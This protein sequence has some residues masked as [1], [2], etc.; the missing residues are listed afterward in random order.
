MVAEASFEM[1]V[2]FSAVKKLALSGRFMYHG[3]FKR[4]RSILFSWF[5]NLEH[6]TLMDKAN[7]PPHDLTLW[8]VIPVDSEHATE[9]SAANTRL[10]RAIKGLADSWSGCVAERQEKLIP[11]F[12][13]AGIERGFNIEV[14]Q[15]T[16]VVLQQQYQEIYK[17]IEIN[18]RVVEAGLIRSG[19]ID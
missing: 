6:L 7:M 16:S 1:N 12:L 14:R 18:H 9:V 4:V 11:I 3:F 5:E 17:A 13:E 19:Y 8:D 15:I 10:A 2:D